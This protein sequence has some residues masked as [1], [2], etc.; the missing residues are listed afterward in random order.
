NL[1]QIQYLKYLLYLKSQEWNETAIGNGLAFLTLIPDA[2]INAEIK[3]IRQRLLY[4]LK[5]VDILG[6]F[7]KP[8]PDRIAELPM[9]F[10]TLQNKISFFLRTENQLKNKNEICK[11]ILQNY[12]ELNFSNWKIPDFEIPHDLHVLVD[13]ISSNDI[14]TLDGDYTLTIPRDKTSKVK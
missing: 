5:C 11:M 2:K 12:A 1:R 13:K 9:E 14:R 3:Q 8:V 4:N 10:N 6:D 7:S